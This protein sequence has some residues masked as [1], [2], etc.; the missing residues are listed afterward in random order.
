MEDARNCISQIRSL[1][2]QESSRECL[3]LLTRIFQKIANNPG[4]EKFRSIKISNDKFKR[5][6]L[7]FWRW[8][9]YISLPKIYFFICWLIYISSSQVVYQLLPSK[10]SSHEWSV[11][12][13]FSS[14]YNREK[15][16]IFIICKHVYSAH[17]HSAL[18]ADTYFGCRICS[19]RR[20][21][22]YSCSRGCIFGQIRS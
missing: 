2:D 15:I 7:L 21:A 17:A 12:V 6:H 14:S 18:S 10:L 4:A 1:P 13:E 3:S 19:N 20:W 22:V 8:N 5:Y 9:W 16:S 11:L